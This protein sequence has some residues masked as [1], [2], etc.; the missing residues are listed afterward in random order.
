M[1]RCITILLFGF[2]PQLTTICGVFINRCTGQTR[3]AP[4][5]PLG[6]HLDSYRL[7]MKWFAGR[8][9]A[10]FGATIASNNAV[11]SPHPWLL[12]VI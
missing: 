11:E 9:S 10:G 6:L 8:P 12:V 3:H 2:G 7:R 5:K 4:Q 1:R